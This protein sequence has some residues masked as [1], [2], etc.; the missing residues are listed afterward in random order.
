MNR[1]RFINQTATAP[2]K[3]QISS[4]KVVTNLDEIL[5]LSKSIGEYQF[6]ADDGLTAKFRKAESASL[7]LE[8]L[9]NGNKI[10]R[11]NIVVDGAKYRVRVYGNGRGNEMPEKDFAKSEI[12]K[13]TF[14]FCKSDS[15]VVTEMKSDSLGNV[16][17][18]PVIYVN[19]A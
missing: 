15:K 5:A 11:L 8:M 13:L 12:G 3:E 7:T 1:Y 16:Y 4:A 9:P 18:V 14:G 2:T 19:V 6:T 10:N 17:E